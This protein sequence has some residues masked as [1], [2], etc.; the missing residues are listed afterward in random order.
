MNSPEAAIGRTAT[1]AKT[2]SESDV[3]LFAGITGDLAAYHVN[4]DVMS[5]SRYGGRLAHGGLVLGL[6]STAS[7]LLWQADSAVGVGVSLGYDRVRFVHPVFLGD[8]ITVDYT[9][10]AWDGQRSRFSA[11]AVV[12][13]QDGEVCL[14]AV[15]LTKLVDVA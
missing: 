6:V 13:N 1:F 4:A 9:V 12:R 7:T 11:D 8:T 3:Y 15:H 14:S 2:I 5:R 10:T